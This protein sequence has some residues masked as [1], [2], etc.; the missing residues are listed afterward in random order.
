MITVRQKVLAFIREHPTVTSRQVSLALQMTEANARHHLAILEEMGVVRCLGKRPRRGK[1]RPP[2]T[3]TLIVPA[4][5]DYLRL[6]IDLLLE[7]LFA[8]GE[9]RREALLQKLAGKLSAHLNHA[10]EEPPLPPSSHLSIRLMQ[11]VERLNTWKYQAHWEAGHPAPKIIVRSCPF[12]AWIERYPQ[13]CH[14]DGYLIARLCGSELRQEAMRATD[15]QGRRYCS[16]S[17]LSR[18]MQ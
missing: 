15:E 13:L 17:L 7:E 11:T 12:E 9:E 1:G 3:Y 16:F 18:S 14:L 5:E 10:Q 6:L 8:S 2:K 4:A